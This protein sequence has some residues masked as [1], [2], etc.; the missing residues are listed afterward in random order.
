MTVRRS[1]RPTPGKAI[2]KATPGRGFRRTPST[3]TQAQFVP[4]KQKNLN[5]TW[6]LFSAAVPSDE[7]SQTRSRRTPQGLPADAPEWMRAARALADWLEER[8]ERG[9]VTNPDQAAIA[10]TWAAFCLG[11]ATEPQILKVAHLVQRAHSAI[12]STPRGHSDLQAAYHAAAGVLHAALPTAVRDRMP[13]ERAVHVVR[14]LR[15]EADP[16]AAIVEG[17]SELLGWKDHARTHAATV[18]R[19]LLEQQRKG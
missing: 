19:A 9:S 12:R 6:P 15:D 7:R 4:P 18:I 11:G 13:L 3:Q 8:I 16:W 5:Q 10:R 1:E 2:S 14:K 17:T